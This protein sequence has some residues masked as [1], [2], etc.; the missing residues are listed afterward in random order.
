MFVELLYIINITKTF[1]YNGLYYSFKLGQGLVYAFTFILT[2]ALLFLK[3]LTRILSIIIESFAIFYEDVLQGLLELLEALGQLLEVLG[4]TSSSVISSTNIFIHKIIYTCYQIYT[5]C[6]DSVLSVYMLLIT[7]CKFIKHLIVLFGAGVWFAI[8]FIPLSLVN[9][10]NLFTHFIKTAFTTTFDG[11]IKYIKYLRC[12]IKS[13]YIF[14]TDVPVE[15]VIGLIVAIC[16]IYIITQFYVTLY[17]SARQIFINVF[18][19]VRRNSIRQPRNERILDNR[20][21]RILNNIDIGRFS[22]VI[23]NRRATLNIYRRP[24]IGRNYESEC[25]PVETKTDIPEERYCVICQE[26]IK[27]ILVLPCRHVCMCME[28]N[29]RLQLY[30]NTCPICRNDIESTMKIFV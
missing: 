29:S 1:I 15:S 3:N 4:S 23:R 16:L 26:R 22:N 27:C 21:E 18:N 12:C 2:N 28:C 13:I 14:V 9:L 6:E 11:T 20:N 24:Q 10:L 17:Q 5:L 8:T 7:T 25:S 30:N 19:S